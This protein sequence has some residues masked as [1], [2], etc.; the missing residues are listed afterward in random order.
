MELI[1]RKVAVKYQS[2]TRKKIIL[3]LIAFLVGSPYSVFAS[4][5]LLNEESAASTGEALSG[6]AAIAE[7]A[8]TN[9]YN[10][11]GLPRLHC[12]QFS[13]SQNALLIK[14][15]FTGTTQARY[16][17][18]GESAPMTG[19]TKAI[20]RGAVPGFYFATPVV[21]DLLWLGVGVTSPT[22]LNTKYP[23]SSLLR[24]ATTN[25]KILTINLN[26]NM[27]YKLCR[28]F[29]I[30][31]GIDILRGDSINKANVLNPFDSSPASDWNYSYNVHGYAYGANFGVLYLPTPQTRIGISY[32]SQMRLE[33][34]GD[35][36]TDTHGTLP[37]SEAAPLTTHDFRLNFKIPPI[38]ILSFYQRL[39]PCWE[40]MSTL[41]LEQ[42]SVFKE[43][44]IMNI[45]A[46]LTAPLEIH[47]VT[48]FNDIFNLSV[49]AR[50]QLTSKLKLRSGVAYSPSAVTTKNRDMLIPVTN[51]WLLAVGAHY[52]I[53]PKMSLDFAL[54][55]V[56][57]KPAPL[58]HRLSVFANS[59][60]PV[61]YTT[62][63]TGT[64]RFSAAS[65]GIQ[66]NYA[67][68]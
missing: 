44:Q 53:T 48:N 42:W 39:S 57:F 64:S 60:I 7:D 19:S 63:E 34:T 6:V 40:I 47:Y 35:S 58:E 36:T 65:A 2:Y 55:R 10:P 9:Y 43:A 59:F 68:G 37:S 41:S 49:G 18:F 13:L 21:R 56:F 31:Y 1:T 27:G 30:G 66:F 3:G 32:R 46:P 5:F 67:M 26:I 28:N 20:V 17:L 54:A 52:Q 22:A 11:A 16:D 23:A 24:Y 33:M 38:T 29:Y 4:G 50:Y 45:P 51:T 12:P 8:S 25:N 14:S 15:R 62:T 61:T